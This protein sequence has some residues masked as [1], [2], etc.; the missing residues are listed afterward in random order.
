MYIYLKALS[1]Y[2]FRFHVDMLMMI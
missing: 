1:V 2:M